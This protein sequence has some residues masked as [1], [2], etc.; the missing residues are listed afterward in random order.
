MC[1]TGPL[2]CAQNHEKVNAHDFP[3][4]KFGK[5]IPCGVYDLARNEGRASAAIDHDAA[6]FAAASI[7]RSFLIARPRLPGGSPRSVP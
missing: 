2:L 1:W 6:Q 7:R 3:D 4:K 5:A